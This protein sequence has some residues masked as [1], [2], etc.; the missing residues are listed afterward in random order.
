MSSIEVLQ[1]EVHP[2]HGVVRFQ[3]AWD[4]RRLDAVAVAMSQTRQVLNET[5]E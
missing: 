1:R 2:S 3:R 4:V 5:R